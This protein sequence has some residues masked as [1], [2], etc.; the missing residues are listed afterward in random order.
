MRWPERNFGKSGGEATSSL[1][2]ATPTTRNVANSAATRA[3]ILT[4]ASTTIGVL[5]RIVAAKK[6]RRRPV[7]DSHPRELSDELPPAGQRPTRALLHRSSGA[8][9]TTNAGTHNARRAN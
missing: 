5:Q 4:S 2:S 7:T 9:S 1:Q 8:P 6:A 3:G